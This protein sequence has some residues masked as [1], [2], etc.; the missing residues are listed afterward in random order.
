M[1]FNIIDTVHTINQK[2]LDTAQ[3]IK[4]SSESEIVHGTTNVILTLYIFDTTV[5]YGDV[6]E[7]Y[8]PSCSGEAAARMLLAIDLSTHHYNR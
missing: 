3:R 4:I 5:F 1:G 2:A 8:V 6:T 7:I